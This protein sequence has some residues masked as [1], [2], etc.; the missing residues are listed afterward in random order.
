MLSLLA[1][2]LNKRPNKLMTEEREREREGRVRCLT[3]LSEAPE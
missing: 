3:W 1:P 2:L